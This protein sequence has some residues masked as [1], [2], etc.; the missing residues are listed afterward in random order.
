MEK[1]GGIIALIAGVLGIIAGF[2]TLFVGGLGSAFEAQGADGILNL[3]WAGLALSMLVVIGGGISLARPRPGG[4]TVVFTSVVGIVYGGSLVA[5]CLALALIGGALAVLAPTR[6]GEGESPEPGR[7]RWQALALSL[8]A[9][10]AVVVTAILIEQRGY[11]S[12]ESPGGAAA[13]ET[14]PQANLGTG[15]TATGEKFAVTLRD[16]ALRPS[17]GL[18]ANL[19]LAPPGSIYAVLDTAVKCVDRESRWYRPGALLAR[20]NGR[21]VK[22]DTHE[23]LAITRSFGMIN[24]LTEE[25][26]L[27]IYT[28]PAEAANAELIWLPGDGAGQDAFLLQSPVASAMPSPPALVARSSTGTEIY[29]LGGSTLEF[30]PQPT[31]EVSFKLLIVSQEGNTGEAEGVLQPREGLAVWKNEDFGCELRFHWQGKAVKLGQ[32]GGCGFGMG[33]DGSGVY[34]R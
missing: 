11:A 10:L 16:F 15:Q 14:L 34:V 9:G 22:F 23:N 24:P 2:F 13:P 19:R 17:V 6:T 31:G 32:H 1:A 27:L 30:A 20:I 21:I 7:K 12:S 18:G 25:R 33:V 28:L 5:L 29:R 4:M 26:S 8:F 3:A